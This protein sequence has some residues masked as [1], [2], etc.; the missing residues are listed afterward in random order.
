MFGESVEIEGSRLVISEP[1]AFASN[2]KVHVYELTGGE[3][4]A[5]QEFGVTGTGSTGF[6]QDMAL[7][8]D[9]LVLQWDIGICVVCSQ[10]SFISF[11]SYKNM[12]II[13]D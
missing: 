2:G 9:I 10:E 8:G 5:V 1:A 6:G 13:F 4:T 12:N 11:Q 3:W 7:N